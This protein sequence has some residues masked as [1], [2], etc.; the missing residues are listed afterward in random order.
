MS[1]KIKSI[2]IEG[3]KKF[4]EFNMVF[5]SEMNILVG[6]NEAGKSTVMEALRL[7]LNQDYRNSDHSV[8]ESLF[9]VD[10][11]NDFKA[12]PQPDNL[13]RMYIEVVLGIDDSDANSQLYSGEHNI[14][15]KI[16]T[17]I[18]FVCELDKEQ[19]GNILNWG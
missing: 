15:G 11:V 7:V 8:L 19:W 13:P 17:G 14:S 18:S 1:S 10:L 9:N 12:N 6:E 5:N 4:M 2:H 3:Y 16:Q